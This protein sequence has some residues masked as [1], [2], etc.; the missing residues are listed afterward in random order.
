MWVAVR[1]RWGSG[2][3]EKPNNALTFEEMIGRL[4]QNPAALFLQQVCY[5]LGVPSVSFYFCRFPLGRSAPFL[6]ESELN[7]KKTGRLQ[8]RR[9]NAVN[10]SG[11]PSRKRLMLCI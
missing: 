11:R 4:V 6:R 5:F 3:T 9:L 2:H 1:L 8:A 10:V 7:P